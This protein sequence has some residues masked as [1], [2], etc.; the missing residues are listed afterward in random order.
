MGAVKGLSPLIGAIILIVITISA[1]V[2]V[3][4]FIVQFV[5]RQTGSQTICATN[6]LYTI[7]SAVFNGSGDNM[8]VLTIVNRGEEKLYGFG[9]EMSNRTAIEIFRNGSANITTSPDLGEF[10]KLG[11]EETALVKVSLGGNA[12]IETA[13]VVKVTN[14]ACTEATAQTRDITKHLRK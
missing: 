14:I 8:L 9:V 2:I 5:S 4:N 3:S 6:A 7:E 11:Q 1:G 13:D 12:L 10:N